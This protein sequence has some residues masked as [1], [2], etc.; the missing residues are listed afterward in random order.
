MTL[1]AHGY[2]WK[3]VP[4]AGGQFTDSGSGQCHK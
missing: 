4:V 1:N 3:F 2:Q